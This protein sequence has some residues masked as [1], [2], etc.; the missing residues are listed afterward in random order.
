M[1]TR[2]LGLLPESALQATSPV[3]HPEWNYRPLLGIVQRLRF[4]IALNLLGTDRFGRILEIGYGSGVF[5]PELTK[6]CDE[7]YGVDPHPHTAE[8]ASNLARHGITA[9]LSKHSVE[10]LPYPTGHFDCVVTV[11]SLEYVPDIDAACQEVRRVLVPGGTFVVVTPG[12]TPLWDLALRLGTGES[13]SQYADRRQK[14]RPALHRHFRPVRDVG[15]P[16]FGGRF[17]RLYTGLRLRS[18]RSR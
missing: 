5:M 17:L 9:S 3:D 10:S 14:L 7:L 16:P 6:R 11:S 2:T 1:K 18:T 4:H 13:P 15:I 12:A 8:V